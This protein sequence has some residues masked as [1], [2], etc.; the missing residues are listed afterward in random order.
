VIQ[1]LDQAR[2]A[3]AASVSIA[4]SEVPGR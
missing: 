4:A 1:V 3:G 2:L